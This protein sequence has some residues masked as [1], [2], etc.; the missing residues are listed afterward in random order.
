MPP[1]EPLPPPVQVFQMITGF[2]VS[3]AIFVVARANVAEH[4][5]AGPVAVDALARTT[6]LN[7]AALYRV[8]RAL[9]S[10]GVFNESA[11]RTFANT[12][13]SEC[14]RPGVPGSQHA[15]ALMIADLGYASFGELEWSVATGQPGFDKVFGAPVFDYLTAHP[16]VA[17][18]F[19]QAM[20]SIHG[21]ETPAMIAAYPFTGFGTIVDVGGGNGSTL[22]EVLNSAPDAAG[23][24]FDLPGVAERTRARI[25]DAGLAARCRVEGGS[26]FAN[27]PKG[28]DAYLLRHIVHDWDD[29]K[30]IAILRRC[31]E[32]MAPGGKVLVVES[33]IPGGDEPHP[34]T[35]LDIVMLAMPGGLERTRAEFEALLAAAGLRLTRVV[36]TR[37]PVSIVEAVAA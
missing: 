24:V 6:G 7:S 32:A 33:V 10:I 11:P 35:W 28:A 30:S 5:A 37:S 27:V 25:Q 2:A 19:D 21:A 12:P 8:L 9:A 22:I 13:L 20:T 15:G 29:A 1:A 3:Q 26:F 34:G 16:E 23:I 4:L 14:L 18:G 36:P 17:R 31:R